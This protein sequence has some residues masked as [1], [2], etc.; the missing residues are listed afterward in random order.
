MQKNNYKTR[1]KTMKN[2]TSTQ[3]T[4][5]WKIYKSHINDISSMKKGSVC[6]HL[7]AQ[8]VRKINREEILNVLNTIGYSKQKGERYN[9]NVLFMVRRV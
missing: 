1:R 5:K 7:Q 3:S 2:S 9:F 4:K 6:V 8:G